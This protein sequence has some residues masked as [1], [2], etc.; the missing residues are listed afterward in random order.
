MVCHRGNRQPG[1]QQGVQNT[2]KLEFL[3]ARRKALNRVIRS[4]EDYLRT[5]RQAA[6]L[7]K[8]A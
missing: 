4:L 8:I 7:L 5:K 1:R 6:R 2:Q 3:Y